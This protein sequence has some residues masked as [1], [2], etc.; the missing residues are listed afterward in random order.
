MRIWLESL[1]MGMAAQCIGHFFS[2]N[3]SENIVLSVHATWRCWTPWSSCSSSCGAG[4]TR[5]K[6]RNFIPGR[7]GANHKPDEGNSVETE[8]CSTQTIPGWPTCPIPARIGSWESWSSCS[9]T[10]YNEGSQTPFMTRR[11]KCTEASFSTNPDFNTMI[12]TCDDFELSET[13]SCGTPL[14]PGEDTS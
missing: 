13:M 11:R 2:A 5:Q 9:Q 3:N 14:C 10:C 4:A 12:A 1:F 8:V 6:S 7:H